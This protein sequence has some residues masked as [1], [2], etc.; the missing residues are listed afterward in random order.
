VNL[1]P[2]QSLRDVVIDNPAAAAVFEKH[3]IDYSCRGS[4]VL[5][6]VLSESGISIEE[7]MGE[8]DQVARLTIGIAPGTDWRVAS[9][10]KLI[11]HIVSTH[12]AYLRFELPA[13]DK[14]ISK[15]SE[16]HP[17]ER[18]LLLTLQR[19]IQRFQRN[20][21]VQISKEEAILF[22]AISDLESAAVAGGPHSEMQFGSV[23]NLSRVMEA[24]NNAA[25]RGLDEI[26]L[27]TNNYL[28][29]PGSSTALKT[30]L[31][32]LRALA[33]QAHQHLHLENNILLP[34]AIILEK[35]VTSCN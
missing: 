1:T 12:H 14:W 26:R 21:E 29:P 22:P 34:R 23:A 30:L 17:G 28:C 31:E 27:L 16:Q 2:T 33:A 11:R 8:M 3:G 9:L 24:E 4:R 6:D 13:L 15:I 35:G 10:R 20:V 32:R 19:A 5:G 7:F 25:A 18:E